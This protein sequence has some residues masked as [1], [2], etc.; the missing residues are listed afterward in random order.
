[1]RCYDKRCKRH[2]C[3]GKGP[4]NKKLADHCAGTA[5]QG[6]Q[7]KSA[8]TG[9]S[10]AFFLFTFNADNEAQ[11]KCYT[12]SLKKNGDLRNRRHKLNQELLLSNDLSLFLRSQG[13]QD[14]NENLR[15]KTSRN[16]YFFS[17]IKNSRLRKTSAIK[18][19]H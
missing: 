6:N 2:K 9:K 7:G 5:H 3:R 18:I 10:L 11:H 19:N 16:F 4:W 14:S 17:L 8:N 15:K 12:E 13:F 1:M